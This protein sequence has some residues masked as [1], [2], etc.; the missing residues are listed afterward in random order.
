[1]S[2]AGDDVVILRRTRTGGR[3]RL[4]NDMYETTPEPLSGAVLWPTGTSEDVQGRDTVSDS[5]SLGL[6]RTVLPL[7]PLD[8][9]RIGADIYQVTG[10]PARYESP[11]TRA[12]RVVVQLTRVT[13]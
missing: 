9:V 13:G 3:D 2:G 7:G 1:M 6:P 10:Q 11:F 5:L 4:G 8:R 12:R